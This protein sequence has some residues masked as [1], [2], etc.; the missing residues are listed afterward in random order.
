[1]GVEN[2]VN[3]VNAGQRSAKRARVLLSAKLKTADGELE[4]RL[5][6]L[7]QKGA[8]I[9]C[10][11]HL[12]VGSEVVFTRG[13]T[14][15]PARVAWASAGR[16]GLEFLRS[17]DESEVLVQLGRSS[18]VPQQRFRRPRIGGEDLS[19]TERKLVRSWGVAV[20]IA[21]TGA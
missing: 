2:F 18:S 17:I 9:E 5:R 10:R 19:E 12:A 4:C 13:A 1:M 8:L 7:S 11:N 21:V 14:I 15:V 20:G 3:E 16:I 6:D